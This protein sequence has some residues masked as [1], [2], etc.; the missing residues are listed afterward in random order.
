MHPVQVAI[1]DLLNGR[2]KALFLRELSVDQ[3]MQLSVACERPKRTNDINRHPKL[4]T[5]GGD[6]KKVLG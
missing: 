2:R 3:E 4:L 6:L 1:L 5:P